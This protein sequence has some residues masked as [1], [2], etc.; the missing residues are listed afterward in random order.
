MKS[1]RRDEHLKRIDAIGDQIDLFRRHCDSAKAD[2][3]KRRRRRRKT[4]VR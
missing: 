1:F 3:L 4:Q 2:A